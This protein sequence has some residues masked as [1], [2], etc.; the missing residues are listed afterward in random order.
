MYGALPAFA[1]SRA[2]KIIGAIFRSMFL[3]IALT[4][5]AT[6]SGVLAGQVPL[7]SA[8]PVWF[9][10]PGVGAIAGGVLVGHAPFTST[11]PVWLLPV[12]VASA[13]GATVR[14]VRFP[15]SFSTSWLRPSQT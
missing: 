3:S 10:L 4:A 6:A 14:A 1:G 13:I 12:I 9:L 5:D 8:H 2:P 11:L 15:R 7:A